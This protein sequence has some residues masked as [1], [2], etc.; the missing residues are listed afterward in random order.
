M[1]RRPPRSTLFPY[2]TLFRSA[3]KPRR[4]GANRADVVGD[5]LADLAVAPRGRLHQL[6]ALVAQAQRQA[7]ELELGGVRDRRRVGGKA[8]IPADSPV[9]LGR[10]GSSG[11]G[12]GG[13]G[14][15]R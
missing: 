4:N 3:R 10:G 12:L 6:T 8:Q 11:V 13:G 15:P 5:V 9:E 2:T 1:I 7:V 14:Q